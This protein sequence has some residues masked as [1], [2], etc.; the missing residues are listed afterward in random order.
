MYS[1]HWNSLEI[2]DATRDAM[3]ASKDQMKPPLCKTVFFFWRLMAFLTR[4]LNL[5]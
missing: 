3:G 2:K 4:V 1:P 5:L